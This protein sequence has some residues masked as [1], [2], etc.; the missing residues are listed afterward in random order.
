MG[1]SNRTVP[2]RGLLRLALAAAALAAGGIAAGPAQA[3]FERCCLRIDVLASGSAQSD[4]EEISWEWRT[5]QVAR[6]VEHGRIFNALT[7]APG[8]G[9]G[10][11]RRGRVTAD[12][13]GCR[14]DAGS[15]RF[16]APAEVREA[17]NGLAFDRVIPPGLARSR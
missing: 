2:R 13:A 14:G 8:L 6:Y 1:A 12:G 4:G 5:R 16:V 15:A 7:T 9:H 3:D 11:V 10:A 17:L